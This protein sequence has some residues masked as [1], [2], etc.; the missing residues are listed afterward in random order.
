MIL[1]KMKQCYQTIAMSCY[2]LSLRPALILFK[3][4]LA[5][6][7]DVKDIPTLPWDFLLKYSEELREKWNGNQF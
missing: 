5:C 7:E 6:K 2:N 1:I 4:Y 3:K